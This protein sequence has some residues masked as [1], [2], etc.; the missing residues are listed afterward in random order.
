MCLLFFRIPGANCDPKPSNGESCV[1][2]LSVAAM[3]ER[4]ARTGVVLVVESPKGLFE[5]V[6]LT[7]SGHKYFS[8][9]WFGTHQRTGGELEF[10]E[11]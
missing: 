1:N 11:L 4:N 5:L 2:A 10:L 3:L 6:D 8:E 9:G 7:G